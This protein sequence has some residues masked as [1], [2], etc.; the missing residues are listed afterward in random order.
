M[1]QETLMKKLLGCGHWWN[2]TGTKYSYPGARPKD[3]DF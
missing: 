2:P 1:A 3:K